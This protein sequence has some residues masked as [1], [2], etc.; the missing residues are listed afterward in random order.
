[1]FGTFSYIFYMSVFCFLPL[2]LIWLRHYKKLC[3]PIKLFGKVLMFSFTLGFIWDILAIHY[4]AWHYNPDKI[5]NVHFVNMPIEDV[6]FILAVPF[7][8]S[9]VTVL[10]HEKIK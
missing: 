3:K 9:S 8:I 5:L 1:M 2:A 10:L 7:I 6:L 4:G